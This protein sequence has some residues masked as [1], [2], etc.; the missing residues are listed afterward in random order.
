MLLRLLH[1]PGDG[2]GVTL[3]LAEHAAAVFLHVK[4][5]LT[6]LPLALPKAR[7][8]IPI[9]EGHAVLRRQLLRRLPQQL[10][11]LI[12]AD[13]QGAGETLESVIRG[14]PRRL[15]QPQAVALAAAVIQILRH[16]AAELPQAVILLHDE[17]HAD[18]GSVGHQRVAAGLV[19]LIGVD[20]GVEPVG[21]R[22]G[23]KKFS[24]P[25]AVVTPLNIMEIGIRPLSLCMR[26][27]GNIFAGFVIMELVKMVVPVVV[28]IPLSLYFDV[29][30]GMIQAVVFVF[31]TTLFLSE[32]LE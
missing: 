11:V 13:E 12:G 30:D 23:L 22:G 7:P 20:V 24:E 2:L 31:L 26:L 19:L 28:P 8:E 18:G 29:F 21:L 17:L 6:G 5:Q 3:L 15:L 16:Q 1:V 9:E 27:F 4:A 25:V 10:V 14:V 32:S